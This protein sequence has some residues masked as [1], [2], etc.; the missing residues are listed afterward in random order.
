MYKRILVCGGREWPLTEPIRR[1]LKQYP[2]GTVLIH[3]ACRGADL[4]AAEVG[5]ELGFI[6]EPYPADWRRYGR[7]AGPIRN[8]QMLVEGKPDIIYAFHEDITKS[9]GTK[10]MLLQADAVGVCYQIFS[11]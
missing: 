3:G 9:V 5:K 4:M 7:G 11:I 6:I 2:K 1:I 10:N 8:K